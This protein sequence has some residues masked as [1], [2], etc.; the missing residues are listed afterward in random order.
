[1]ATCLVFPSSKEKISRPEIKSPTTLFDFVSSQLL[2]GSLRHLGPLSYG[3]HTGQVGWA[4]SGRA[5]VAPVS[6]GI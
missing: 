4:P 5:G 6:L 3:R 2:S 1:M